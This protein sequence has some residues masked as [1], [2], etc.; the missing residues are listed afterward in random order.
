MGKYKT[1]AEPQ[2]DR[3]VFPSILRNPRHARSILTTAT[4]SDATTTR[5]KSR[6]V[7]TNIVREEDG[8]DAGQP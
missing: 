2:T 4:E 8:G 5:E 6:N 7:R 3:Y 1:A